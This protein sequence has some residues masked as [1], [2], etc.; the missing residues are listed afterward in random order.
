VFAGALAWPGWCRNGRDETAALDALASYAPR[1][2]RA[3]RGSKVGFGSPRDVTFRVVERLKGGSTTDFGAPGAA[4]SVD[5]APVDDAELRRLLTLLRACWRTF[6]AAV[7]RAVGVPLATGPR[8]GGR[9]LDRIVDHV[10]GA[11]GGYLGTLGWKVGAGEAADAE[12]IRRAI[13]DGLK[14]SVR[15]AIPTRGPR[16]GTR[17]TAPYFV[18]RSAWHVLDHA[19]EIEDRLGGAVGR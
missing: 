1:Y 10:M 12:K 9:S 5:A 8:G 4:P 14:A 7:E 19:W 3:L 17:W 18:R 16:G 13:V 11:D 6:D 15:G 2:A